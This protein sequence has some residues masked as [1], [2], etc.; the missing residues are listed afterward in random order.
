MHYDSIYG[1]Y[2]KFVK[3]KDHQ[4]W[5]LLILAIIRDFETLLSFHHNL[6]YEPQDNYDFRHVCFFNPFTPTESI[7]FIQQGIQEFCCNEKQ[8]TDEE[9]RIFQQ[10]VN[11]NLLIVTL[12]LKFDE[13]NLALTSNSMKK[14]RHKAEDYIPKALSQISDKLDKL[15]S[16]SI[17]SEEIARIKSVFNLFGYRTIER[18]AEGFENRNDPKWII[19]LFDLEDIDDIQKAKGE[20]ITVFH[21]ELLK[22]SRGERS[23]VCYSSP[24]SYNPHGSFGLYGIFIY[25]SFLKCKV[26]YSSSEWSSFQTEIRDIEE[27]YLKPLLTDECFTAY[28]EKMNNISN[29]IADMD[30]MDF[31]KSILE[32]DRVFKMMSFNISIPRNDIVR[33]IIER[34]SNTMKIE[35]DEIEDIDYE[36]MSEYITDKIEKVGDW[37]KGQTRVDTKDECEEYKTALKQIKSLYK[38]KLVKSNDVNDTQ[39]IKKFIYMDSIDDFRHYDI[40]KINSIIYSWSNHAT[41]RS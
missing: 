39:Y 12:P 25:H 14:N 13:I 15:S 28:I 4:E 17:S 35:F 8:F 5:P 34:A 19:P 29:G 7:Y 31:D 38:D 30:L 37:K 16:K 2:L 6:N 26:G 10:F 18:L 40:S 41:K 22:Y 36:E 11:T 1:F 9:V 27:G 20:V 33:G 3:N 24:N 23:L 21:G 32:E